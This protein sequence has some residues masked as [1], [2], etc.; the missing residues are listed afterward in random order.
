M[1]RHQRYKTLHHFLHTPRAV[2]PTFTNTVLPRPYGRSNPWAAQLHI[3]EVAGRNEEDLDLIRTISDKI[4]MR[5]T[6]SWNRMR[7]CMCGWPWF[8]NSNKTLSPS[9]VARTRSAVTSGIG[10]GDPDGGGG[11]ACQGNGCA[12]VRRGCAPVGGGCASVG[13]RTVG[14]GAFTSNHGGSAGPDPAAE[15]STGCGGAVGGG[16]VGGGGGGA[17]AEAKLHVDC[18]GVPINIAFVA[19]AEVGAAAATDPA[20][21][22]DP[23]ADAASEICQASQLANLLLCKGVAKC[24]WSMYFQ[25]AKQYHWPFLNSAQG[26]LPGTGHTSPFQNSFHPAIAAVST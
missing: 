10:G 8:K 21:E 23:A 24:W 25:Q 13:G 4:W 2:A 7:K 11:C 14:G 16:A 3:V 19:A 6:A 9:S 20:A 5:P 12:A 15:L 1:K 26:G 18:G 17:D 22:A